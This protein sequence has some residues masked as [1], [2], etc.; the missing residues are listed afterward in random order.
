MMYDVV[1]KIH[2]LY[3]IIITAHITITNTDRFK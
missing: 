2:N 3:I 1:E